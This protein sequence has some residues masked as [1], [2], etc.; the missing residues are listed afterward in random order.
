MSSLIAVLGRPKPTIRERFPWFCGSSS[1]CKTS[2]FEVSSATAIVI[3]KM[4]Y[5]YELSIYV[6]HFDNA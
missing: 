3:I 1:G 6:H 2:E 5:A 4:V